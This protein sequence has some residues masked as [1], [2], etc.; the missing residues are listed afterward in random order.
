MDFR[1]KVS[2][3]WQGER[4]NHSHSLIFFGSCFADEI[5]AMFKASKF[6]T[7][8]NPFGVLYNPLSIAEAINRAIVNTPFQEGELFK[9]GN[10]YH[11]SLTTQHFPIPI[12]S[13]C[14]NQ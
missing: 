11:S 3:D 7:L 13:I 5:G 10:L 8:V 1:T 14:C 6:N 2:L 9:S 12:R 4:L